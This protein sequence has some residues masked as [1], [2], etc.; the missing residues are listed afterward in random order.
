MSMRKILIAA[1]CLI[2]G[3]IS[4][5]VSVSRGVAS[6]PVY[7]DAIIGPAVMRAAKVI[8]ER[9]A[10]DA[11]SVQIDALNARQ[12]AALQRL[13]GLLLGKTLVAV[14]KVTDVADDTQKNGVRYDIT[15][16]GMQIEIPEANVVSVTK[17]APARGK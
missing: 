11:T 12:G 16:Y 17:S 8:R 9:P 3:I 6:V 14:F 7:L 5:T 1:S 13:K 10:P 4:S 2:G 15:E